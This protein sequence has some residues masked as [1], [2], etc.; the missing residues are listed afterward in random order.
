MGKII[1]WFVVAAVF[2]WA[3]SGYAQ[4]PYSAAYAVNDSI[5]TH[6]D[7]DQRTRL[8]RALG[9]S[10]GNIRQSA[11]EQLID[12]RLKL[13]AARNSG[14]QISDASLLRGIEAAASTAGTTSENLWNR[15]RGRGVSR[16]AFEEYYRTRLIWREIVQ[17]R[18]RQIADPTSIEID[19]AINAAAAVT[20]ES[21]L[22]AEIALPFAERGEEATIA[23]A[24]RLSR[25]LNNGANFDD[26]VR[27]FSRSATAQNGGRIGWLSPDRLPGPIA[28]QVLGLRAGQVSAPVRVSTG[29][30]LLKVISMRVISSPLKKQLTLKYAVLDLSNVSN[31]T[32]VARNMQSGLDEC[33]DVNSTATSFAQ[34]SGIFGPVAVEE[35]PT[36]IALIL[37]RLTPSHSEIL[38]NGNS[39]KLI[40]LCERTTDLG[41]EIRQRVANGVFGQKL[42][43]L[44]EGLL[45]ELRRTAIIEQR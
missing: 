31:A 39:I 9:S 36:D 40:Q 32:S 2:C 10:G 37:A 12:D 30:L 25:D 14:A 11:V 24:E 38:V 42:G 45:L 28:V 23:F 8:L 17:A 21:I 22:L 1:K 3:P 4:N 16:L 5:I 13:A 27:N 6:F 19:N 33:S 43:S 15:A 41:E 29:V 34:G 7:I 26:A 20:Q 18:F 35:I 44:A